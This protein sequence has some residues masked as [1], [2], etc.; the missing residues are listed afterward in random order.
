MK[1]PVVE[2]RGDIRGTLFDTRVVLNGT[3]TVSV[4]RGVVMVESLI[5]TGQ[6]WKL[7][8]GKRGVFNASGNG[9]I[10]KSADEG[11]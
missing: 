6:N 4:I 8:S 11:E 7:S 9:H 3:T 2:V 5:E 10:D 1:T